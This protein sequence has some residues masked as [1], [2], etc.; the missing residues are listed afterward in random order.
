MLQLLTLDLGPWTLDLDL[1]PKPTS[2]A[3]LLIHGFTSAPSEMRGLARYLEA[4]DIATSIPTLPGH[5]TSPEDLQGK[6]W[7]DWYAAVS[8]ELDNL[9]AQYSKVYLVGLSLGGALALYAAYRRGNELAG[10]VAMSAPI[11]FPRGLAPLLKR[12]RRRLPYMG[13]PFRDIQDPRARLLH[14]GYMRAP[15]DAIASVVEFSGI[16]RACLP[17]IRVPAL[18]IYAR[19]DHVVHPLNSRYI[20]ARI[21][22]PNKRLVALNRG[23]HIVTVDKD[24]QKV[25]ASVYDFLMDD[26]RRTIDD[27]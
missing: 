25:Y 15:I 8:S 16:V 13:K 18:I 4:R 5:G 1:Q 27:R 12:L 7:Q 17:Q 11:Y 23:F 14:E 20:Y 19:R 26:G 9:R 21:G 22:S 10:I 3:C 6:T 2:T 24:R